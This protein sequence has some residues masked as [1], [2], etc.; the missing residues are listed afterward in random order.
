MKLYCGIQKITAWALVT[1]LHR[2]SR[3]H[4]EV[5][6]RGRGI[7]LISWG[8]GGFCSCQATGSEAVQAKTYWKIS[9]DDLKKRSFRYK[10]LIWW[11]FRGLTCETFLPRIDWRL[12]SL[13]KR[14]ES[15]KKP[16]SYQN[17]HCP[18]HLHVW[19]GS[20]SCHVRWPCRGG[21]RVN[22]APGRRGVQ[23][24]REKSLEFWKIK[25]FGQ[26]LAKIC[27]N[28]AKMCVF[29]GKPHGGVELSTCG[30]GSRS[31]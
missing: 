21:W 11:E 18:H 7:P 6:E 15:S 31:I 4:E 19:E 13:P 5:W 20:R 9:C 14:R 17:F 22:P 3:K 28:M 25:D 16:S 30:W 8:G 10:I 26:V 2:N 24:T 12:P 23:K 27:K 1:W 29:L